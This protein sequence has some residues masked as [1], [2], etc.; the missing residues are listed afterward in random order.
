[1]ITKDD[2]AVRAKIMLLPG[3]EPGKRLCGYAEQ[4]LTEIS[5]AFNHT[6]TLM[7]DKT[8]EKSLSAHPEPLTDETVEALEKCQAVLLC[9]AE[10]PGAPELYDALELPLRIRSFCVPDAL[11]GRHGAPV[12][13]WVGQ[14]LSVDPETLRQGMRAA[15]RFAQEADALVTLVPPSGAS[16]TE[17][18]A[19]VR[20]Q[21]VDSPQVS[22]AVM[23]APEAVT[24]LIA[25]P[26]RLGLLLCPPYAGGILHA[27]ATALCAQPAMMH[28]IAFND[29]IGVYAPLIPQGL[30]VDDELNPFATALSV[31]KLLRY[32]LG[33]S[34]E[35]GCVEAAV[36][37]VLAAGWRTP[38]AVR[39]GAPHVGTQAVI[40]LI[41]E[42]IAVAGE[43]MGKGGLA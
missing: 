21:T 13:L 5:A 31:A 30:T 19:A 14:M 37:N 6:F 17:W 16:K 15:F 12:S 35:A 32:S 29:R 27:A 9:D 41:C 40:E 3:S 20:V 1:M 23:P 43:L 7:R 25:A 28:D 11:C 8:G 39:P 34:R 18:D 38:D 26:S 33:L 36:N 42:Q 24:A 10:C 22:S 2:V 4:L